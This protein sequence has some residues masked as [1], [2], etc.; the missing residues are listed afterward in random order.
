MPS[1]QEPEVTK[2]NKPK[3]SAKDGNVSVAVFEN[4]RTNKQGEAFKALTWQLDKS[5]KVGDEWKHMKV[6]MND[7]E[8]K[9]LTNLLFQLKAGLA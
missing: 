6:S 2:M 9:R 7:K 5:Y 3:L 4:E 1:G 8:V